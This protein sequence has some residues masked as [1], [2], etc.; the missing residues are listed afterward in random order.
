[1][2]MFFPHLGGGLVGPHHV[3]VSSHLICGL[4]GAHDVMFF[5]I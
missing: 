4:V 1:M 2:S 3:Y 5:H